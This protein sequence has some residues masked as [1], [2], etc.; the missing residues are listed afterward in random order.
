[1]EN[2]NVEI[3][4]EAQASVSEALCEVFKS[5]ITVEVYSKRGRLVAQSEEPLK[6]DAKRARLCDSEKTT[7]PSSPIIHLNKQI[8]NQNNIQPHMETVTQ[9]SQSMDSVNTATGEEEVSSLKQQVY[10]SNCVYLLNLFYL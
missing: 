8:N 7:P 6:D 2:Q 1:M 4:Q 9:L 10:F 5:G 3:F